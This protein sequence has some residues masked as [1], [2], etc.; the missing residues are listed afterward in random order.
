[1]IILWTQI[2]YFDII[3]LLLYYDYYF[4]LLTVIETIWWSWFIMIWEIVIII[5]AL[6]IHITRFKVGWFTNKVIW[7][8]AYSVI[9]EWLDSP[10]DSVIVLYAAV[11]SMLHFCIRAATGDLSFLRFTC[12]PGCLIRMALSIRCVSDTNILNLSSQL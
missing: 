7:D 1:M 6:C 5:G 4:G 10:A 12:S 2:S 8:T 3:W 11:R 9:V